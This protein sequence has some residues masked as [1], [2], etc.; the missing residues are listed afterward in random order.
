MAD[1]TLAA[2]P[3]AA[4][5]LFACLDLYHLFTAGKE[6][7]T[8]SQSLI[9]RFRIQE[10]RLKLWGE[11]WGLLADSSHHPSLQRSR[12]DDHLVLETLLRIAHIL[13]DYEGLKQRYGL[14]LVSDEP[15]NRVIVSS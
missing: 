6:L 1:I 9:W 7:G 15:K 8:A 4:G 3:L 5:L 12:E 10:T 14:C 11:E 2:I 13:K